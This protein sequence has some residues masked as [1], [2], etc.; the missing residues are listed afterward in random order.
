VW[1][2]TGGNL[3]PVSVSGN[4]FEMDG[5]V[6]V[7]VHFGGTEI[8][9]NFIEGAELGIWTKVGPN[10]AGGNMI[11]GNVIGESIAN[12][13]RI[14]DKENEVLG[15]AVYK[16]GGAGIL[17]ELP[18]LLLFPTENLIGG[19]TTADQNN[20]NESG[21][22]AIKIVDE[23]GNTEEDSLN[24]VGQ[25]RERKTPVSS[26]TWSAPRMPA[27]CR[28]R[29]P[30]RNRLGPAAAARNPKPR[31]A[32]SARKRPKPAS[33]NRSSPKRRPTAAAAG[34]S[35]TRPRSRAARLSPPP[36]RA[37]KGRRLSSRQRRQSPI[38]ATKVAETAAGAKT[39]KR[40]PAKA[41]KKRK[42]PATPLTP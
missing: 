7:Q 42:A 27:S 8:L 34:A 14:E 3:N 1:L 35:P 4:V 12:G 23:S 6:A 31:F 25:N 20:I 2:L 9:N 24:E 19:N 5:G 36:R 21:G 10:A 39:T 15:N 38:R 16:S 33:S 41:T 28:R 32:S 22:P 18:V 13:V 37:S 26:S 11:K 17:L 30:P 40:N 29:S